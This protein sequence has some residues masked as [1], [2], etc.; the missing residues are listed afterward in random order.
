MSTGRKPRQ[1]S[2]RPKGRLR[3]RRTDV[4][5]FAAKWTP[6]KRG[7]AKRRRPR[8]IWKLV[9][10]RRSRTASTW[11]SSCARPITARCSCAKSSTSWKR[12]K[13]SAKR[14]HRSSRTSSRRCRQS[15]S[16][17]WKSWRQCPLSSTSCGSARRLLRVRRWRRCGENSSAR[18]SVQRNSSR[19]RARWF[20]S[21]IAHCVKRRTRGRSCWHCHSVR[22][23]RRQLLS[24]LRSSRP[25]GKRWSCSKRSSRRWHWSSSRSSSGRPK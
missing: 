6:S 5:H 19:S 8:R 9:V 22:R 1:R 4:K 17:L 14:T 13:V 25:P 16:K 2:G 21:A 3:P 23:P 11:S 7:S 12:R 15:T 18:V 10:R 24:R 20:G